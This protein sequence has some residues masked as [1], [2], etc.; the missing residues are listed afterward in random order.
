M[1]IARTSS[2]VAMYARGWATKR[3]ELFGRAGR[4]VAKRAPVGDLVVSRRW[5]VFGVIDVRLREHPHHAGRVLRGPV[6]LLPDLDDMFVRAQ[7]V[8]AC[9]AKRSLECVHHAPSMQPIRGL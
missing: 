7:R 8:R 5:H 4:Q 6:D 3:V 2:K 1:A 9:L